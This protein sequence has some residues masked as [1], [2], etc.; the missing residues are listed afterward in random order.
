MSGIIAKQRSLLENLQL[1]ARNHNVSDFDTVIDF[2]PD[3]IL[4]LIIT[5]VVKGNVKKYINLTLVCKRF[6]AIY[7]SIIDRKTMRHYIKSTNPHPVLN[8]REKLDSLGILT[9]REVSLITF[10][11]RNNIFEYNA[12]ILDCRKYNRCIFFASNTF[13]YVENYSKVKTYQVDEE[14]ELITNDISGLFTSDY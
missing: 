13:H 6:D 11:K 4:E 14:I 10:N 8:W 9:P 5:Y 2:I 12:I 1:F 3:E 7:L